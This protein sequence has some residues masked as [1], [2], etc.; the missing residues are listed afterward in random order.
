MS[1][2][3][4][5]QSCAPHVPFMGFRKLKAK[6]NPGNGGEQ[7]FTLVQPTC[8]LITESDVGLSALHVMLPRSILYCISRK[9][10][11]LSALEP[12]GGS[13]RP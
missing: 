3:S 12:L 10:S 9:R 13:P 6:P 5:R 11:L 1:G 4:S 2:D 7:R 8:K